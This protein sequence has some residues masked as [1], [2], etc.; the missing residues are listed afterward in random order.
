MLKFRTEI[1]ALLE[2][3]VMCGLSLECDHVPS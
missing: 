1:S 2:L 3:I